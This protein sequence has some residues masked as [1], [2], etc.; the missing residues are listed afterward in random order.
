LKV[1]NDSFYKWRI[2]SN[3]LIAEPLSNY[4]A[5]LTD[6]DKQMLKYMLDLGLANKK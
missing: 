1:K 5:T 6:K 4:E 3:L 2:F